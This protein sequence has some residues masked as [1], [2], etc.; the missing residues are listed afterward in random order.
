[1]HSKSLEVRLG[2]RIEITRVGQQPGSEGD[3]VTALLTVKLPVNQQCYIPDELRFGA[4]CELMSEHISY[5]WGGISNDRK[6]R[7]RLKKFSAPTWREAF[8]KAEAY[9]LTEL[10]KLTDLMDARAAALAAAEL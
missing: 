5:D 2:L 10:K 6:S 1:M 3:G 8:G 9:G 7:E 4:R